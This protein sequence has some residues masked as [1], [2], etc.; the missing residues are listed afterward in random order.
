RHTRSKRDWSSDVCSSDLLELLNEI[1]KYRNK[2]SPRN[3]I[4]NLKLDPEQ[5]F[6]I[7][8]QSFIGL[9]KLT[10][11]SKLTNLPRFF[12]KTIVRYIRS[13]ERRVGKECRIQER[14]N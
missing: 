14:Y 2:T 3:V 9:S 5:Q 7:F 4:T 11:Q 13:E 6:Q 1:H 12:G 8:N 10:Y